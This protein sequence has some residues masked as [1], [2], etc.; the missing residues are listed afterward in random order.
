[1][2]GANTCRLHGGHVHAYRS[3]GV[4]WSKATM[5]SIPRKQLAAVGCGECPH[6]LPRDIKLPLSPI[7]RGRLY[8]AWNN[9]QL[10]PGTW[11]AITRRIARTGRD[12][13]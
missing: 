5:R 1:L 11:V 2:Q 6:D 10:D 3:L 7:D 4:D 12:A 8:E 9:R 13:P